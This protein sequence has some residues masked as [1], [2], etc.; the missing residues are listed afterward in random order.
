MRG[1]L[2]LLAI[3]LAS[4]VAAQP[5]S[6]PAGAR[7]LSEVV[8]DGVQIYA[9]MPRDAGPA[10]VFQSPEAALFDA[11]GRQVGAHGAGPH[12]LWQ[13]GSRITGVVVANTPAPTAGAIP[14]LLLRATPGEAPGL[15]RAAA[16]VRRFDTVGGLPPAD[17]CDATRLGQAIRMRYSASYGFF[18]D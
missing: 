14:W 17:G 9:C 6:P 5:V 18:A 16:W 12:W 15:L 2:A 11:A 10:W 1:P 3:V 8:A 4:P 13:D 7:L